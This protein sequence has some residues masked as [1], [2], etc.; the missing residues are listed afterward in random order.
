MHLQ[1]LSRFRWKNIPI[2]DTDLILRP[3]HINDFAQ[4]SALREESRD[5]LTPW[6][7][8]WPVNDLTKIGYQRR[9]KAYNQQWQSGW[10]R[11][12]FLHETS[13][14]T[15]LGG[16]SLTRITYRA[17]RSATLGYWMGE[18]YSNKGFMKQTVPVILDHAFNDLNLNRVEA[19]CVPTNERSIHLLMSCG[20]VKEGFAREYLEIN[21]VLEDHLLFAK[22]Q[23]EH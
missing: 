20:F 5:F 18:A 11:T 19:A 21:G 4:W 13:T 1:L 7:P 3:P 17:S 14:N 6:E 2:A 15:L 12:Y 16:I 9:M 8:L 22:L 23:S 10:G